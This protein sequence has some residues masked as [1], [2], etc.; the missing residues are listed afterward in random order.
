MVKSSLLKKIAAIYA[1]ASQGDAID[2]QK[3]KDEY[4][5]VER[6]RRVGPQ[7]SIGTWCS[8]FDWQQKILDTSKLSFKEY[9]YFL[10]VGFQNILFILLFFF[11]V[12]LS[13][14][15]VRKTQGELKRV[16]VGY[17]VK[18]VTE[19]VVY[20]FDCPEDDPADFKIVFNSWGGVP[21]QVCSL[22][23][24]SSFLYGLLVF[25]KAVS[26]SEMKNLSDY[27]Y[28]FKEV[29]DFHCFLH[30][31]LVH[32]LVSK[33]SGI[34]IFVLSEGFSREYCSNLAGRGNVSFLNVSP[35]I[36]I[37]RLNTIYSYFQ[38][39]SSLRFRFLSKKDWLERPYATS[40]EQI[41]INELLETLNTKGKTVVVVEGYSSESRK[42]CRAL[43]CFLEKKLNVTVKYKAHPRHSNEECQVDAD[44][45]A[46]CCFTSQYS[47]LRWVSDTNS[48]NYYYCWGDDSFH[49]APYSSI[50]I[51]KDML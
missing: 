22:I 20:P 21:F 45:V 48:E 30:F 33:Y 31:I 5:V 44:D 40:K 23:S 7:F 51:I 43:F 12:F 18:G 2:E 46:L 29:L 26:R 35:T 8:D 50:K 24:F 27:F 3:L 9:I 25:L 49:P 42:E 6:W 39:G 4:L 13:K 11:K 15:C 10:R 41:S 19:R 47:L 14:V 16:V 32:S 28:F 17:S 1:A 38:F 36:N 34:Q 37:A